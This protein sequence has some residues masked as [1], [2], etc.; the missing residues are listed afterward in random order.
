MRHVAAAILLAVS[1]VVA[2]TRCATVPV[3]V[4]RQ[5]IRELGALRIEG[6]AP[7]YALDGA[8]AALDG[9]AARWPGGGYPCPT[10]EAPLT[11]AFTRY[12]IMP[13]SVPD[14]FIVTGYT[15]DAGRVV[16]LM[17]THR[18]H[19]IGASAFAH[20]ATHVGLERA[21]GNGDADHDTGTYWG[22]TWTR[23]HT[24]IIEEVNADLRARGM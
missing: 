22:T 7:P 11:I 8:W 19:S 5:C 13:W 24:Q 14:G 3:V 12:P 21:T 16:V 15:P 2:L 4:S 17:G 1:I 9:L 23:E 20:E 6:P 18:I 10:R